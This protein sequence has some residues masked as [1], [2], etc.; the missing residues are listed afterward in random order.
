L[1]SNLI[2]PFLPIY[3]PQQAQY[4]QIKKTSWK[5]VKKFIKHLDKSLLVKSKDR[6]GGETIILDVDFNDAQV[7][8]FV[9]YKLPRKLAPEN[10]AANKNPST[11]NDGDL[12]VG[13]TLTVQTLYRP[14]GKL[15]P[16]L[17]PALS[18]SDPKNYYTSSAVSKQL[19]EYISSQDPSI[20]SPSNPRIIL[21]NP[22]IS[23][24]ILSSSSPNDV[25]TLARGTI[26]R[27]A[28]LK[29]LLEDPSLCGPYHVILKPNQ[30]LEEVKPKAGLAPKVTVTIERRQ[31]FRL[32]TKIVG[33]EVFGISPTPLAEELQKKC[34][35]S[36]SV[37]QAVGMA[38]GVT[39]VL[40]QGDHRRTV[41]A[42][43]GSRGVRP[44]WVDV[45]DKSKKKGVGGGGK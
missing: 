1:I 9:P 27:E 43:L 30:T 37:S 35:S 42:A 38:K 3:S 34:A 5:S 45:V 18:N 26:P 31:G 44:Q 23:N 21:L 20:I 25:A 41:E 33:L 13:H 40:V 14:S 39:E 19:N 7:N 2:T 15:A 32:V 16:V 28:L 29:R 11:A 12:S 4:Y 24:A 22:F 8:E 6:S 17:F 10:A 36:T